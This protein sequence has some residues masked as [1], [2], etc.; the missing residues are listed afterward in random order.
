[1]S[2]KILLAFVAAASLAGAGQA[3]AQSY[4]YDDRDEVVITPEYVPPGAELRRERV[5]YADLDISTHAGA[6]RLLS[7]INSAAKRVCSPE[8]TVPGEL[9]DRADYRACYADA[10][11][12]AVAFVDAPALNDVFAYGSPREYRYTRSGDGY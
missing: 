6:S 5:T 4:A 7:R 11:E 2:T 9:N 10:V 1:M 8:P 12:R 3:L